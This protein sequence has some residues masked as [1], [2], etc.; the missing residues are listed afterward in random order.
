[1]TNLSVKSCIVSCQDGDSALMMAA[2]NVSTE[3]RSLLVKAGAN[4]DLN[5]VIIIMLC[6]VVYGWFCC[7]IMGRPSSV[8]IACVCLSSHSG[9][10]TLH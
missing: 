1:M 10:N 4:T 9:M 3:I 2:R 6:C 8:V 7:L 5:K